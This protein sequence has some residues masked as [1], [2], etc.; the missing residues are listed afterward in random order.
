MTCLDDPTVLRF[1]TGGL[2]DLSHRRVEEEIGRCGRCA[3]LVAALIRDR[4]P[5]DLGGEATDPDRADEGVIGDEVSARYVL[6]RVIARGGMGTIVAAYDR[7]LGRAVAIKRLD[8]DRAELAARFAR[9]I[10]VTA[11]LQHPRIVPIY[12]SGRLPDRRPF[13]AMRHVPGTSLEQAIAGARTDGERMALLAP[14][15][16]AAEA[17]AYAHERGVVHRD[18]KPSNILVGPF[19][20]T[21]VIDWGLARTEHLA[22]EASAHEPAGADL[23]TTLH[24]TVLGTPRTMS[25]EQARG[26]RASF[27]SDVYSLGGILYHALSGSPPV[28]A[29][30]LDSVLERVARSEVAPLA[31][32]VPALPPDLTAIV[33]RAM[34]PQP[35]ERYATAAE[36]AAD[37]RRFQTG[38]LVA[39]H[40]YSRGDLLKRF[41]RRHRG[42]VIIAAL[43][44]AV[45]AAVGAVSV[46]R[47]VSEREQADQQRRLAERERAGAEDLVQFLVYDIRG[48]LRT[49]GRLDVLSGVADRIESYYLATASGRAESPATLRARAELGDLRAEVA[50]SAGDGASA[51]R[52]LA[53]G[54]SLIER[55]P[56]AAR[57]DEVRAALLTS[58]ALRAA[59][60][61][62]FERARSLYLQAATLRRDLRAADP[63]Q[64]RR[65][66]IEAAS[67]LNRAAI[68]TE[69]LGAP[70][71]AERFW[72]EALG[73]LDEQ[74]A[75]DHD[76]VEAA[77]GLAEIEMAVGQNRFR[78]GD[79]DGAR[80]PLDRAVAAADQLTAR[81]PRNAQFQ[82]LLA[83]AYVSRADLAGASGDLDAADRLSERARDAARLVASIEP[84][85][86]TWRSILGR[87]EMNVGQVALGR[88]DWDRAAEHLD[89]ARSAYE[90]LVA[91]DPS[92]REVR[93]GAA[94]AVAQLAEAEA[95]RGRTA[96]ARA[97]WQAAL[98]H[99][100]RL[101]GSGEAKARL[102]WA[103][104][105]RLYAAF[106]RSAGR[107]EAADQAIQ[108]AVAIAEETPAMVERPSELAY[109]AGVLLEVGRADRA[110]R[111][112]AAARRA[113]ERGAA[114][115]RARAKV[116]QLEAES[117]ELLRALD[118][119][120]SREA[121]Q[122]R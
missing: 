90:E 111:R 1:V 87:A 30:E 74:M 91:R 5:P 100:A 46:R 101:A 51:D 31:R 49:V 117:A 21:V 98:A 93:R 99:F 9:E 53:R 41:V 11:A 17:V 4:H 121:A 103:N 39:A 85:S 3:A 84:A 2:D 56:P 95:G 115:L 76:D 94:V 73:L 33:D 71:D 118:A 36:L 19:G 108:Q 26:E 75:R 16:A 35:D 25:P 69:R 119:E 6:G 48:K 80:V 72:K 61:G 15:L 29:G 47:I 38:Q 59:R 77:A 24:G 62:E 40:S 23:G 89:A 68:M 78:R 116:A 34:A 79:A 120:L 55:A 122:R 58:M 57:T 44:A 86:A 12:D 82:R 32:V 45:I 106:E 105:L 43:C 92:D 109:R 8:S 64:R 96:G 13:F 42:A 110:H 22:E 102:E 83:W 60:R 18:L 52:H 113:W 114:L 37:L 70:P 10:R 107:G 7:R 67:L 14:V 104:G 97:A 63:A 50:N 112:L 27:P 88:K 54:M 65:N 20:E 81:E 66:D 28:G